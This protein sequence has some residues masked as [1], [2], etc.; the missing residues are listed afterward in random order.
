MPLYTLRNK[1]TGELVR[2][3]DPGRALITGKWKDIGK[4]KGPILRGL[5]GRGPYFHNGS[6]ATLEDAIDF[7]NTR[8]N[9]QLSRR[10][11]EDLIAFLKTL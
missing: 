8:F 4:F 3:T 7:Y 6:A 10:D 5:A 9:L 1:T 11:K 2:T